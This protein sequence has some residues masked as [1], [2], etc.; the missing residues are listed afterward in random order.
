VFFNFDHIRRDSLAFRD[1]PI[2]SKLRCPDRLTSNAGP[3]D[4]FL[5]GDR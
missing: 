3:F 1:L 4:A 2:Q 5:A